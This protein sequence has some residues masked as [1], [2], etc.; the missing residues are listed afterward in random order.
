MFQCKDNDNYNTPKSAWIDIQHLIP[1]DKI[2]WEAFYSNGDSGRFLR[3]LGFD[4]IH[5]PIDFFTHDE[6]DIVVS[7]PPF[8]L[9]KKVIERLHTLDKPF[10]LL[11]PVAKICYQYFRLVGDGLQLI[12]PPKR[13]NFYFGGRDGGRR[14]ISNFDCMY[15]CWKMN[16]EKDIIFLGA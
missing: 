11:L 6:G 9:T 4:V 16:F 5:E 1:Q 2:V 14:T 15:Y 13:I 3:E 8:S 12:I 10:I 7:N